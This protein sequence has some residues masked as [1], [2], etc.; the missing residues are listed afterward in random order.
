MYNY[1]DGAMY[2]DCAGAGKDCDKCGYIADDIRAG[3]NVNTYRVQYKR[4][5]GVTGREAVTEWPEHSMIYKTHAT[6]PQDAARE[7]SHNRA[8]GH[9]APFIVLDCYRVYTRCT[10]C[11]DVKH[12]STIDAC[13]ACYNKRPQLV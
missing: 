10:Q 1:H 6:T 13:T 2:K 5:D 4:D 9:T 3:R 12:E 11:G 7:W 8:S